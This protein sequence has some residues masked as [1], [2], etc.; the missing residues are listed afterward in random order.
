MPCSDH[1]FARDIARL[2]RLYEKSLRETRPGRQRFAFYKFLYEVYAVHAH[3]RANLGMRE[4]I[5]QIV[6]V[7]KTPLDLH[8]HLLKLIVDASCSADF[9]TKSRWDQAL[10]YVWR[11]RKHKIMS[12]RHK[13]MSR[14]QFD[15]FLNSNG[16]SPSDCIRF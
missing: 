8:Q 13:I 16:N 9:K 1:Q 3:W 15:G 6:D 12:R 7:T 10:R 4:I 11:R 5:R 14:R 2:K